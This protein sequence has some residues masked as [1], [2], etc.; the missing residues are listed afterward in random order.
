[1]I[2]VLKLK[3]T[4]INRGYLNYDTKNVLAV[5]IIII[6]IVFRFFVL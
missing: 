1:M 4:M 6:V 5:A 2:K 3:V